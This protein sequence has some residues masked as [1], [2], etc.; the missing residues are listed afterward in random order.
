VF[1]AAPCRQAEREFHNQVMDK[2]EAASED[3]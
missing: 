1:F 2:L 3:L